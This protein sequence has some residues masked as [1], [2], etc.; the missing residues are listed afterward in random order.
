MSNYLLF[1]AIL[2]SLVLGAYIY[3]KDTVE[4]E[5]K[6]LLIKLIFC[7]LLATITTLFLTEVSKSIFPVL[8]KNQQV[9]HFVP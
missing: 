3:K 9:F 5:S 4:K 1:L 7:G 6:S 8:S 2:P